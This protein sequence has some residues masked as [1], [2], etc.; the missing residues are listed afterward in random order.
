MDGHCAT[1]PRRWSKNPLL[2]LDPVHKDNLIARP[3]AEGARANQLG[4]IPALIQDH[5]TALYDRRM[6]PR[7]WFYGNKV[8][9]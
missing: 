5:G 4:K 3:L 1:S 7:A 8:W 2:Y 6:P 9:R